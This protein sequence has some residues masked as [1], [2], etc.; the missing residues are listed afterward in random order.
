MTSYP[1]SI[2]TI[3]PEFFDVFTSVGVF[4]RAVAA[5]RIQVNTINPRDFTKDVHR[6]VDDVPFGG[7]P[8]M[9]FK[10]QP[11]AKAIQTARKQ[12][13]GPV[14]YLSPAGRPLTHDKV[15][16]LAA[17]P[18]L[19]L[20][21]G[22]YEGVD[23]RIVDRYVD[24]EISIGDYVLS[25]GEPAAMVVMDAVARQLPGVVKESESVEKDAFYDGLL[26]HPHYTR[27]ATFS[28]VTVPDVLLSGDH[29]KI[30]IWRQKMK[31]VQTLVRRPD[32]LA[33]ARLSPEQR[34][35]LNE[36]RDDLQKHL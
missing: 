17:L 23:Q 6:T 24:E 7:G 31:L 16:E 9:V 32:L 21:C 5:A 8:G 27:P 1:F 29:R 25:G 11:V 22:R 13:D 34:K 20:L 36:I 3:F 28:G 30:E 10:P 4:G 15:L 14:V 19:T 26:D 2:I 35:W 12:H 33:S 18:G